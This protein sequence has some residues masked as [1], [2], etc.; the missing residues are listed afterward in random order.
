MANV[1]DHVEYLSE[2]IGARTPGTEEERQAALYITDQFQSETGFHTEIEDFVCSSNLDLVRPLCGI[3]M[4]VVSLIALFAPFLCL[5]AFII[6][7]VAAIV[8]VTETLGR[9]LIPLS[10]ARGASQNVVAK[11]QPNPEQGR[12]KRTRKIVLVAHYDTGRVRPGLAKIVQPLGLP[13]ALI[14]LA[15]MGLAVLLL[16]IRMLAMGNA[17]GVG[18]LI[19]NIINIVV[20]VVVAIPA[21]ISVLTKRA[22]LNEGANNNATGVAAILEVARRIS[23]GSLSEADLADA[24]ITMHGEAAMFDEELVPEGAQIIYESEQLVPPSLEPQTPEERLAKAKAAL[25]AFAGVPG[26]RWEPSDIAGNLVDTRQGFAEPPAY[27]PLEQEKPISVVAEAADADEEFASTEPRGYQNEVQEAPVVDEVADA[28]EESEAVG[29]NAIELPQAGEEAS[30]IVSWESVV[31]AAPDAKEEEADDVAAR[32]ENAPD[33]F[34]QAQ[35][36]ARKSDSA[37]TVRPSRYGM[38]IAATERDIRQRAEEEAAAAA[39]R[40]R[41][42]LQETLAGLSVPEPSVTMTKPEF[43][44]DGEVEG[45]IG[46]EELSEFDPVAMLEDMSE[47]EPSAFEP[48]E[49]SVE[50]EYGQ[51]ETA[52]EADEPLFEPA[53]EI[54]EPLEAVEEVAV[55]A[56]AVAFGE[57]EV[58]PEPEPEPAPVFEPRRRSIDLPSIGTMDEPNAQTQPSLEMRPSRSGMIRR[59]R[60]DIPSLSGTIKRVDEND[61]EQEKFEADFGEEA[62]GDAVAY[63]AQ[64]DDAYFDGTSDG[65]FD[66]GYAEE[67]DF[68]EPAYEPARKSRFGRLFG[69]KGKKKNKRETMEQSPQEW[70]GVDDDFDP[71]RVGEERGGWESFRSSDYDDPPAQKPERASKRSYAYDSYDDDEYSADFDDDWDEEPPRGGRR[72]QGGAFSRL[73]LGRVGMRS[74]EEQA[75]EAP[76]PL[77]DVPESVDDTDLAP[78]EQIYHFRNPNFKTEVWFVALGSDTVRHDGIRAFIDEHRSELRGALIVEVESLG[79][80]ELSIIQEEGLFKRLTASSRIRRLVKKTAAAIGYEP[81]QA[82]IPNA[83]TI[84]SVAANSGL[85]TMHLAGMDGS[86]PA[87]KGSADDTMEHIDDQLFLDNVDYLTEL[88][89]R[90]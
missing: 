90:F 48:A 67:E 87:M 74:G 83:D 55:A 69:R 72:W 24:G 64:N 1:F 81:G 56:P 57:E 82:T 86:W 16:L 66:D 73:R 25:A 89:Q 15:A 65:Y 8:F 84:T 62:T 78:I 44:L 53:A 14:S 47:E 22:P 61:A 76:A 60:T 21:V 13:V 42:R 27:E 88:V 70:L 12:G 34:V 41:I 49:G 51:A 39:E 52:E 32:F 18:S 28:A 46:A 43:L 29:K 5:P 77:P 80:G 26:A 50:T 85:Q 38:A 36:K 71:R 19:F 33:W 4:V 35:K 30:N 20:L 17:T 45:A 63:G 59:L 7:L 37:E 75:D 6:G 11:Y 68:E 3:V 58:V 54:A 2:E 10:F 31:A 23:R 40:E 9:S 79:A